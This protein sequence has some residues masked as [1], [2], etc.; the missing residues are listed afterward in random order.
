MAT[1]W[2]R[3]WPI[4]GLF[5][6]LQQ[7]SLARR[8]GGVCGWRGFCVCCRSAVCL[9]SREAPHACRRSV[10]PVGRLS[11]AALSR[12][13]SLISRT[14]DALLAPVRKQKCY[15]SGACR[16]P[17]RFT[18]GP[19]AGLAP[20]RRRAE[21][22]ARRGAGESGA[23]PAMTLQTHPAAQHCVLWDRTGMRS[24]PA[25]RT[26]SYCCNIVVH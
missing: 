6:C 14:S 9:L 17:A 23:R 20:T 1:D 7:W 19:T 2:P 11:K 12:S 25:G 10:A 21:T 24:R 15:K 22:G 5:T 3:S 4:L 18:H 16:L 26:R 8:I 13:L